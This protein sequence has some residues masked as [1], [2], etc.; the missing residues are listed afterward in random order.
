MVLDA[1]A[2]LAYLQD[3]KG[4]DVVGDHLDGG[5]VSTVNWS[6]VLQKATHRGIDTSGMRDDFSGI[7]LHFFPFDIA[8][9][10][11]ASALW[12][13]A[14]PYGLSFADRACPALG[15][16]RQEPVLSANRV[17]CNLDIDI[18]VILIR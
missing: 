7:G 4:S 2:I 12:Q 18:E 17:W 3:D 9:A 14:R 15:M 10:E 1:S 6:E 16:Q 11:I 5:R 8:H 13:M